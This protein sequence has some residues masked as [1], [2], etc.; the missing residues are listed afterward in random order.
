MHRIILIVYIVTALGAKLNGQEFIHPS[1]QNV[2]PF[3]ADMF[4]D[5]LFVSASEGEF[6]LSGPKLRSMVYALDTALNLLD[7]IDV[8]QEYGL[9][10]AMVGYI[11]SIGDS[12]LMIGANS[13]N[14]SRQEGYN[15]FIAFYDRNM[16]LVDSVRYKNPDT[17]RFN[18]NASLINDSVISIQRHIS[19]FWTPTVRSAPEIS[20]YDFKNR[21][22]ISTISYITTSWDSYFEESFA[23]DG[24]LLA[25]QAD[26]FSSEILY[27][28]DQ[29]FN[30][31]DTV[32]G[33]DFSPPLY[34]RLY[35]FLHEDG[36]HLW[37]TGQIQ[38]NWV[39]MVKFNRQFEAV[40]VDSFNVPNGPMFSQIGCTDFNSLDK[41]MIASGQR[42]WGT[43]GLANPVVNDVTIEQG[44]HVYSMDTAGTLH[45]QTHITADSVYYRPWELV[46]APDGGC[47]V[48]STKYDA[49]KYKG[50]VT[51]RLSVIKVGPDGQFVGEREIEVPQPQWSFYPNPAS[52]ELWV[53]GL[54]EG[55]YTFEFWAGDGR[56]VRKLTQPST[57]AV[58]LSGL[59]SGMY[60]LVISQ[61]GR[62]LG[63]RSVLVK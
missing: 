4:G 44:I 13:S 9:N 29:N 42:E 26:V 48:I 37:T 43:I 45:W 57:A 11:K 5:A 22:K 50:E 53:Q 41:V 34:Y 19:N 25:A 3:T 12:L 2:A 55:N 54:A 52:E 32:D 63:H 15:L 51:Y 47:F 58:S 20:L 36:K 14:L 16:N 8:D 38:H 17:L 46:A 40:R 24:K 21:K 30:L 61:K 49:I 60:Q 23:F 31:M 28:A 7:S 18:L 59:A 39:A 62:A 1:A 33:M 27:V 10:R 6:D 35:H 56:P